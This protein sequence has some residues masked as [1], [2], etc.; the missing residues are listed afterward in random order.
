[1]GNLKYYEDVLG[2]NGLIIPVYCNFELLQ[3][4]CKTL[5]ENP[6]SNDEEIAAILSEVYSP[7]HLAAMVLYRYPDV[8][9]VCNFKDSITEAITAH[10]LGLRHAAVAALAPVVE[11]IGNVL[12]QERKLGG[13]RLHIKDKFELL[14]RHAI[15]DVNEKKIGAYEEV[16]S[17]LES[18]LT[19]L[20]RYYYTSSKSYP[21]ADKTN[22]NGILHGTY[23]DADY[24]SDLN[25]YKI[26][27][28]VDMLCLI[29]KFQVLQPRW[30]DESRALGAQFAHYRTIRLP[31][32]SRNTEN[33]GLPGTEN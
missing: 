26:L 7:N 19:F 32:I 12:Y 29:S 16:D 10:F 33:E 21:L 23:T 3:K 28:A 27:S 17:M 20:N 1:M 2:R 15:N 9:I 25:F 11:G 18:F 30:T 14:A 5:H 8:P 13:S 6:H 4:I 31:M 24:G 22:R